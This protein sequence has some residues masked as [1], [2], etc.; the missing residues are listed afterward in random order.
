GGNTRVVEDGTGGA[1]KDTYTI[2]LAVPKPDNVT[3]AYIT[4]AATLMSSKF[5]QQ[6]GKSVEVSIDNVNFYQS[7]VLAFDAAAAPNSATD[8]ARTQT[9]YAR[10]DHDTVEEGEQTVVIS[11]SIQSANP[12]FNRLLIPNVEVDLV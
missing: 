9:I 2:K 5:G 1:D 7:L 11:H 10:A 12:D 4:V 8:W 3:V 6:G